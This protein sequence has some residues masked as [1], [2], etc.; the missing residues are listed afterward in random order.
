[1]A[2]QL[3]ELVVSLQ[4]DIARFSADMGKASKIANEHANQ[5]AKS[6][7]S[8]TSVINGVGKAFG[9]V[10]GVLA[11]GAAFSSM[12]SKTKEVVGE[13]NRLSKSFGMSAEEASY[14]RVAL[15]DNFISIDTYTAANGRLTKQIVSGGDAIKRL[16]VDI[17]DSSG[18]LKPAHTLML[19]VNS[20]LSKFKEGT[21]RNVEAQ[22]IYGKGWEQFRDILKLTSGGMDEAIERA[23]KLG[24]VFNGDSIKSVKAYKEA[25]K[26]LDDVSESVKVRIG[27]KLIPVLTRMAVVVGGELIEALDKL[28]PALAETSEQMDIFWQ[29]FKDVF[30]GNFAE[31]SIDPWVE[32]INTL[33]TEI[34]RL[35]SELKADSDPI[36]KYFEKLIFGS[37]ADDKKWI[38]ARIDRLKSELQEQTSLL[39]QDFVNLTPDGRKKK[40]DPKRSPG[41][42]QNES[43][44]GSTKDKELSY[45]KAMQEAKQAI[46]KTGIE[47]EITQNEAQYALGLQSFEQYLN[48]EKEMRQQLVDSDVASKRKEL[49]DAQRKLTELQP[50]VGKKGESRPDKDEANR[51]ELLTKIANAEKA[52]TEAEAKSQE[53]RLKNELSYDAKENK[54]LQELKQTEISVADIN[55]EYDKSVRLQLQLLDLQIFAAENNSMEKEKL[56]LMKA[57]RA[58]LEK[59]TNV[60]SAYEKGFADVVKSWG[61]KAK[62]MEEIGA[63]TARAMQEGFSDFF[64][65]A[66]QGKLKTLEDYM[67]AF[68]AS[69]Q[70]AMADMFSKQLVS[71]LQGMAGGSGG[72]LGGLLR[73]FGF[74][75]GGIVG[76]EPTFSRAVSPAVFAGAKRYHSGLMSD[77]FPAILQKGESVL[78]KGQ[79]AALG[80]SGGITVNLIESPGNGGQVQQS[81]DNN[82]QS[83]L[84]ILVEQIK[85]AVAN[86]IARGS[87]AIPNALASTYGLNRAIGAY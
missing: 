81:R 3:G 18:N 79:M 25:M 27:E 32:R 64:F 4:A 50:T 7:D 45:L 85:G 62:Q 83:V 19:E 40:P 86:D 14:L 53:Q 23:H 56:E 39:S 78:T 1:M 73:V 55:G 11:G 21:D 67:N 20:A 13:V 71:G 72:I 24:L 65:D 36:G 61:S 5:I 52:L 16:G 54:H 10:T 43:N 12:V 33:K 31:T 28:P 59:M 51:Y 60:N 77:E 35:E 82:G 70:R 48:R 6:F 49:E 87:G 2:G 9:V 69:V 22:K 57:Q 46:I 42:N 30:S 44:F 37:V 41:A 63:T 80:S 38:S 75:E 17:K 29:V 76:S 26:D 68:S 47:W 8:L 58:E 15:D 34:G 84:T 66:F 74:H